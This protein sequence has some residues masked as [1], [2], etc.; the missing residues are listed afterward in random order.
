MDNKLSALEAFNRTKYFSQKYTNYFPVYDQLFGSFQGTNLTFVEIGV[1][2]GGSLSMFKDFFGKNA[3]II[4]I[5][6]NK[7]ALRF[8]NDFEIYIGDQSDPQFWDNFF[9]TVGKIDILLDDGGHKNVQQIQ[10]V[11]SALPYVRD[12]G[13]IVIEDTHTSFMYEFGNPNKK[14]FINWASLK[15]QNLTKRHIYVDEADDLVSRV[16]SISFFDSFVSFHIS[17]ETS[18]PGVSINNGGEK[19]T[20]S[21]NRNITLP[22]LSKLIRVIRSASRKPVGVLKKIKYMRLVF[23]YV[24]SLTF[25][26]ESRIIGRHLDKYF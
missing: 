1:L 7:S 9:K 3:R 19:T 2:H 12:G 15:S 16:S 20:S 21:D 11:I 23:K 5:D 14:S 6:N 4:G 24:V 13:L 22:T 26:I 10:T 8:S 18:K 25:R 17:S